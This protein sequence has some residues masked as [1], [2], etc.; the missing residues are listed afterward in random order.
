MKITKV[1]IIIFLTYFYALHLQAQLYEWTDEKGVKHYSNV[2][3]SESVE[4]IRSKPESKEN[5]PSGRTPGISEKRKTFKG[6]S[7]S[8]DNAI[9][10]PDAESASG[11]EQNSKEHSSSRLDLRLEKFP[12]SQDDLIN[13]EKARLQQIKKNSEQNNIK[14]E[15]LIR[16]EKNRLLKAIT[17]LKRAPVTKFGSNENKRRQIGYY[18]YRLEELSTSPETYFGSSLD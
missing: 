14:P 12:M 9:P 16:S 2:A 1:L 5:R 4:E 11:D 6:R 10:A 3:P 13:E 8:T 7:A 18:Q 15:E 17:D